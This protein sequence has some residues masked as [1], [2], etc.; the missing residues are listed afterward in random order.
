[1]ISRLTD[2]V[3]DS[4]LI[5]LVVSLTLTFSSST[6]KAFSCNICRKVMIQISAQNE[7]IEIIGKILYNIFSTLPFILVFKILG[8]MCATHI[9]LH[10]TFEIFSYTC[11][12]LH[13]FIF[14]T[15]K[16]TLSLIFTEFKGS[17]NEP[18]FLIFY[19][20]FSSLFKKIIPF[21]SICLFSF[22]FMIYLT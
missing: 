16:Y 8:K 19:R 22:K 14:F 12:F 20:H 3:I 7:H 1:M 2:E 6:A 21:D 11:A 9:F 18:C 15:L 10:I 13:Q 5:L 4:I 17:Q